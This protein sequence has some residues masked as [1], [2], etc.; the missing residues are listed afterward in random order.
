MSVSLSQSLLAARSEPGLVLWPGL[1]VARGVAIKHG[2][3]VPAVGGEAA[4]QGC[5]AQLA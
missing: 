1:S 2:A 4:L 5:L 3:G